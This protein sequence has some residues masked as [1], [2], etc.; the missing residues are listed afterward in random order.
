MH[1]HSSFSKVG[2]DWPTVDDM[3]QHNQRLLV[4]TL[5]VHKEANE[6]IAYEWRYVVE[7]QYGNGGMM[8]GLCPNRAESSIVNSTIKSLVL[9]NYFLDIPDI[10]TACEHNSALLLEMLTTCYEAARKRWPNFIAVDF[11]K[12]S[13][14]GEAAE[15]VDV[16]N[17]H[18]QNMAFRA[19]NVFKIS[20]M[21]PESPKI[22]TFALARL[23]FT[24][25]FLEKESKAPLMWSL[26]LHIST[27]LQDPLIKSKVSNGT[28]RKHV[29][30]LLDIMISV[31]SELLVVRYVS[32]AQLF[33]SVQGDSEATFWVA[34]ALADEL[35]YVAFLQFLFYDH[36]SM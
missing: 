35:V 10:A 13:D 1:F 20:A 34:F 7:N 9:M 36:L 4:F 27:V 11:Y 32:F 17:G 25:T 23:L 22:G 2:G 3:I 12:R 29:K 18:L 21:S 8:I 16:A 30:F 24:V 5:N 14:G 6:G 31:H 33:P 15:A 26:Q 28:S 19:C